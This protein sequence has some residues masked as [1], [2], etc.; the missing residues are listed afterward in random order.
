MHCST[1]ARSKLP[2]SI[3][4][5]ACWVR[6]L[7]AIAGSLTY[8]ST[9][10]LSL[11]LNPPTFSHLLRP[12]INLRPISTEYWYKSKFAT[13]LFLPDLILKQPC[14]NWRN[15]PKPC[16]NYWNPWITHSKTQSE[17]RYLLKCGNW[18]ESEHSLRLQQTLK[19]DHCALDTLG[20][21][22]DTAADT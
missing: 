8:I 21:R 13:F 10:L 18:F 14:S 2:A 4:G 3:V 1:G 11:M 12:A 15:G 16:T 7:T 17:I 5:I 22:S 9:S 20:I 19:W 6:L